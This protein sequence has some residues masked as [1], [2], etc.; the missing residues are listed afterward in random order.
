[1]EKTYIFPVIIHISL[2]VVFLYVSYNILMPLNNW[3][4]ESRYIYFGNGLL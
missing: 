2:F 4:Y 3:S 1:M